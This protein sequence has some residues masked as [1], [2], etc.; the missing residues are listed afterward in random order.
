MKMNDDI[1][2]FENVLNGDYSDIQKYSYS[3]DKPTL[4]NQRFSKSSPYT[5]AFLLLLAQ[6]SP[7]NLVNGNRIDLGTALSEYNLKEYHHIFPRTFL[8]NKGIETE[9]INSLCN[10]AFLPADANK[11]ISGK[12]PSDYIF[13]VTPSSTY[14]RILESNLMPLRKEIYQKD[15]YDTFLDERATLI[16]Q[17]LDNVIVSES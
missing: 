3:V 1:A 4:M 5:R 12:S 8:R 13:N 9:K 15:Q 7:L 17:Y 11:T 2:F 10:F 14:S 6:K 16:L